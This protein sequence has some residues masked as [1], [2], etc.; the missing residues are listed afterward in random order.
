M[1]Y[2][3]YNDYELI[4]KI[5]ENDEYSE[6]VMFHKYQ[7]VIRNLAYNCYQKYSCYGYDY[8]DFYQEAMI[9]FHRALKSYDDKKDSLFYSFAIL[10]IKRSLMSFCRNISC[11]QKNISSKYLVDIEQCS[12]QDEKSDI[13]TFLNE[14]EIQDSIRKAIFDFSMEES[15]ILELKWNG[16]SYREISILLDIPCSSV[17]FKSRKARHVI[18]KILYKYQCK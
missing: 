7:P 15:T 5:R 17:E 12:V 11:S 3:E 10:C 8:D 14:K 9:S 1:N 2:R 18:R 16:F 13:Q 6:E 4:D